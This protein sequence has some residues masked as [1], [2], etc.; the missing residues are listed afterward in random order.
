MLG[1]KD[2]PASQVS[3]VT[4]FSPK[5]SRFVVLSP[6]SSFL[7]F[8]ELGLTI[9]F[10][11]GA[12]WSGGVYSFGCLLFFRSAAYILRSLERVLADIVA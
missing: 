4:P 11:D 1:S 10:F 5:D 12:S 3:I 2:P 8:G 6:S 7:L 9:S